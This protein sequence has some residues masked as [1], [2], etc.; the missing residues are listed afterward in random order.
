MVIYHTLEENLYR[1]SS[2][3]FKA[4]NHC[5]V[6]SVIVTATA[7]ILNYGNRAHIYLLSILG[8]KLFTVVFLNTVR[9]AG[10]TMY[11]SL[12]LRTMKSVRRPYLLASVVSGLML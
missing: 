1:R 11:Q 7:T 10:M 6:S 9:K 5:L 2:G 8:L 3:N 12:L 4:L